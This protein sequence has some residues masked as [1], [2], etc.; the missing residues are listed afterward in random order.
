MSQT[1]KP[2]QKVP[3]VLEQILQ[4]EPIETKKLYQLGAQINRNGNS[5]QTLHAIEAIHHGIIENRY[6]Q[7]GKAYKEHQLKRTRCLQKI[8]NYVEK[9]T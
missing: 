6:L 3:S 5:W 9:H 2:L 4:G 1:S 8:K 7:T